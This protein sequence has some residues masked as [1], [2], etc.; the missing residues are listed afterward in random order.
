MHGDFFMENNKDAS[1]WLSAV[2]M[3]FE[4]TYYTLALDE[5]IIEEETQEI[6]EIEEELI[7]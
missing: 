7:S 4:D 1:L 5:I 6:D 2:N 3:S